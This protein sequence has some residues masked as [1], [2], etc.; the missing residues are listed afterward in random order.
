MT[1]KQLE[2]QDRGGKTGVELGILSTYRWYRKSRN[3]MKTSRAMHNRRRR[4]WRQEPS[5]DGQ[6]RGRTSH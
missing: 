5:S 6:K 2:M 4:L 1:A 3:L